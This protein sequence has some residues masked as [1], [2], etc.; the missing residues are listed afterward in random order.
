M[1]IS[2]YVLFLICIFISI[3]SWQ[4]L[5]IIISL[6]DNFIGIPS[7]S[8][9]VNSNQSK[10]TIPRIIHQMWKSEDLSTYPIKNSHSEWKKYYP[11]YQIRLWTDED[12]ED[13]LQTNEYKYLYRIYKSY[14]YSIE[15]ADL[16]RLIILH[17]EGGIYADLDVFPNSN[18]IENLVLSNMSL[19]IPRSFTG[20]TLIN[21]FL[22]SQ[23]SSTILHFI[24]HQINP[25]EFYRKIYLFPYL[26][27]F[28]QGS[29]FLTRTISKYLKLS[30]ENE[31]HLW[32]LSEKELDKYII[33][34]VGRSWHSIDGFIFNLIDAKPKLCSSIFAFFVFFIFIVFKY[35]FFICKLIQFK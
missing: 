25:I 23:K 16:G 12:L 11:N 19:I 3:L 21:H 6:R 33:H 35:R 17:S 1:K 15:R 31:N 20:S 10:S 29:F 30:N 24:L 32:I 28:S 14:S 27:V 13:L 34:H 9:N 2:K 18:Q 7:N 26:Q 5:L 22:I 8:K 4:I